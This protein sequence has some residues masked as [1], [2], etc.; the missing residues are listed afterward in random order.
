MRFE[1]DDALDAPSRVWLPERLDG[2]HEAPL[3]EVG[4]GK[5]VD[6]LP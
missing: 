3:P 5:V 1:F 2:F 6:A 4:L